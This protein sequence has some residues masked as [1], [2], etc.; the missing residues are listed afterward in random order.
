MRPWQLQLRAVARKEVQQIRG[1]RRLLPILVVVPLVQ[2]VVFS[3]AIDFDVDHVPTAIVDHDRTPASREHIRRLFA[4]G[5]LDATTTATSDDEAQKTMEEGAVAATLIV[6]E[7]LERDLLRGR[8]APLQVLIDGTDPSRSGVAAG[9][10]GR[11]AAEATGQRPPLQIVPRVYYNPQLVTSIYMVPGV[12]AMLLVVVTTLVTAMGL[13]REREMGTLEQVMVTPIPPWVLLIGKMLPYVMI[14]LLDVTF[15]LAVGAT[16]FD[17]PLRGN[18]LVLG[19][20][21]LLYLLSTLGVGLFLSTVSQNQ[22]QAFMGGFFFMMPAILLSG[23][24][25]PISAMPG[26]MAWVTW[27]NPLRYFIE[28]LR[29]NLL[30]GA[31]V[32]ELWPQLLAL[33]L[34]GAT[35]LTASVARFRKRIG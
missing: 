4:D 20:S 23:N 6:P 7:G 13:A 27:L 8:P 34:F 19:G 15:A 24:M 18:L 17:L 32:A 14:G 30:K 11:Y 5:T 21:T 28:I 26:W 35:I 10:V 31:G 33:A 29:A 3:S 22:Q 1:D 2:T 12:V 9:A 25:T 16:F